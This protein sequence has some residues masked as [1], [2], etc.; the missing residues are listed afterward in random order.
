MA[1]RF[2]QS[3]HQCALAVKVENSQFY[4]ILINVNSIPSPQTNVLID[5]TKEGITET[6]LFAPDF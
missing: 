1:E 6:V 3:H 5:N 2:R 4:D